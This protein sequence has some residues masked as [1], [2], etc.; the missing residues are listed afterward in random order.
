VR[1]LR[2]MARTP[3]SRLARTA[4][5]LPMRRPRYRLRRERFNG[6]RVLV[7]RPLT[8][9]AYA[10]GGS[11]RFEAHGDR[12]CG[13]AVILAMPKAA[14][15]TLPP[16]PSPTLLSAQEAKAR[17]REVVEGFFFRRPQ[18][19]GRK[20]VGPLVVKNRLVLGRRRGTSGRP[21]DPEGVNG[22][23]RSA[24]KRTIISH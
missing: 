8:Q 22:D 19:R 20:R 3:G 18:R 5:L 9:V 13:S 21:A 11:V 14:L 10:P 12:V 24:R 23:D 15:D 4:G 17:L 7:K 1:W 2:D 6:A 16:T